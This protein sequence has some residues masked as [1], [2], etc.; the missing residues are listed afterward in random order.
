MRTRY[1][2][3]SSQRLSPGTSCGARQGH[4]AHHMR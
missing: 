2:A 4:A 3:I 1:C